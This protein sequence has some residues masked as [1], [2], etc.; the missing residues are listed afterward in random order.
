M[1]IPEVAR[2]AL[3]SEAT[4]YRYFPD[5]AGLL[6]EAIAEQL[7]TPEEAL[8]PVADSAD[9][10]ARIGGYL[11]PLRWKAGGQRDS[12]SLTCSRQNV[13]MVHL[14]SKK[15]TEKGNCVRICVGDM[16]R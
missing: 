12:A 5:L 11:K 10:V 15:R 4:A 6:Q 8:Q 2:A 16:F 9:P 3:V 13:P 7:P 14:N 1:T